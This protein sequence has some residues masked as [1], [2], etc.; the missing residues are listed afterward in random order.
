MWIFSALA[1]W[2]CFFVRNGDEVEVMVDTA[3][4]YGHGGGIDV[5][6]DN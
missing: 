2:T 3:L 5:P 6:G 1:L 4:R